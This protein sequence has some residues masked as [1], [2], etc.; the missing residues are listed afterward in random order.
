MQSIVG[1]LYKHFTGDHMNQH[2]TTKIKKPNRVLRTYT[3][4]LHAS[5]DKVF[6]L[7]CPVRELDW[8]KDWP[9]EMAYTNSGFAELG[10]VFETTSGSDKTT[11]IIT[12]HD[13]EKKFVEMVRITPERTAC[14]LSIHLKCDEKIETVAEVTHAHTSLG[15]RGDVF[16]KEFT[17]EYYTQ[18]MT[19]WENELNGYLK[20]GHMIS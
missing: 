8:V 13:L 12:R 15:I 11:W 19:E 5:P 6:P 3:Q 2:T 14:T 18:M 17:E 4:K 1:C 7:L 16:V 20:T 10:C 9:L